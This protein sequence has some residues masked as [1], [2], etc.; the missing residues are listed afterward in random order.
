MP[1]SFDKL[2]RPLPLSYVTNKIKDGNINGEAFNMNRN[3][4]H[5]YG[6][7][8]LYSPVLVVY[9][10]SLFRK[11]ELPLPEK[12]LQ[13]KD[14]YR[15]KNHLKA[16]P[17]IYP[18]AVSASSFSP[19]MNCIFAAMGKGRTLGKITL[20]ELKKC[21]GICEDLYRGG[22]DNHADFMNGNVLFTYMCRHPMEQYFGKRKVSFEWDML[23]VFY[24]NNRVCTVGAESCFISASSL[25][26]DGIL[27]P[28]MDYLIS[29]EIQN[30]IASKRFC[31]PVL[32]SSA[33][34]SISECTY[35]DDYFFSECRN[36]VYENNLFEK[37]SLWIFFSFINDYFAGRRSFQQFAT[38]SESL[39]KSD[40]LRKNTLESINF[41]MEF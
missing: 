12:P 30:H 17:G 35:R 39:F 32:K 22:I 20:D 31:I 10:K 28:I 4:M 37:D 38:D 11:L 1:A 27:L 3:S 9:N 23:P 15:I 19:A 7:P 21:L 24:N 25:Q 14:V 16:F 13:L 33:I 8:V 34:D 41:K 5:Y 18:F 26:E 36:I 2:C 29:P 6:V 40:R